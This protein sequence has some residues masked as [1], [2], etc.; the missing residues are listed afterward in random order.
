MAL[1][2]VAEKPPLVPAYDLLDVRSYCVTSDGFP[3]LAYLADTLRMQ[4]RTQRSKYLRPLQIK[5]HDVRT[6]FCQTLHKHVPRSVILSVHWLS[7][8]VD[9]GQLTTKR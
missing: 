9:V 4:L 6:G 3:V 7:R 1:R 8:D 2:N 5:E